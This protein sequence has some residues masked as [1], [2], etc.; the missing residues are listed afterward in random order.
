MTKKLRYQI[1]AIT[2]GI[3]GL[4]LLLNFLSLAVFLA[5]S[6]LLVARLAWVDFRVEEAPLGEQRSRLATQKV[7]HALSLTV[8][9]V[10]AAFTLYNYWAA[11]PRIF[12]NADH[13]VV[14][15]LG[16]DFGRAL[17]LVSEREPQRALWDRKLGELNVTTNPTENSFTLRGERFFE[18][19]Y[20]KKDDRY[21]LANDAG[22]NRFDSTLSAEFGG[23]RRLTLWVQ[24]RDREN[25]SYRYQYADADSSYAPLDLPFDRVIRTGISLR[26]LLSRN[27]VAAPD[28]G[29]VLALLGDTYLVR[30]EYLLQKN[31]SQNTSPLRLFPS[32]VWADSVVALSVDGTAVALARRPAFDLPLAAGQSFYVGLRTKRTTTYFLRREGERAALYLGFPERHYLR[33]S[34]ADEET[35]F[36]TSS[37]HHIT[38]TTLLAGL[39]FDGPTRDDNRNHLTA[40]LSYATGPTTQKMRFRVVNEVQ[41]NDLDPGL[42][43]QTAQAGDTL[44]MATTGL[45]TDPRHDVRW[46]LAVEDLKATN[47]LP[48]GA[49]LSYILGFTVLALLSVQLTPLDRIR[50]SFKVE[51]GVYLALLAFMT[52]RTVILWRAVTFVP[53]D[54][55]TA[56]DYETLRGLRTYFWYQIY[57][58][59]AFFGVI[60]GYKLWVFRWHRPLPASPR[61]RW[62]QTAWMP[63]LL[64]GLYG[65]VGLKNVGSLERLMSVLVPVATYFLIDFVFQRRAVARHEYAVQSPEYRFVRKLNW[66]AALGAFTLGDAGFAIIFLVFSLLYW[67]LRKEAFP[68]H[69]L[70]SQR[71]THKILRQL[72]NYRLILIP[73]LLL[74]FIGFSPLILSFLFRNVLISVELLLGVAVLLAWRET[75]LSRRVRLL[76]AGILLGAMG[77]AFAL[78]P[79]LEALAQ[80]KN[81][82][83]YRAEVRFRTA[84]DIIAAEQFNLGN[85]RRLLNAAQNQWFINYFYEK[86]EFNLYNYFRRV[87]H[88]QQGSSYLTQISDL[89]SVRYVIAEHSEWVL[90]GLILLLGLLTFLSVRNRMPFHAFTR[91]RAQLLCFLFA[92]SFTIWLAASDRMVF[93]GQDFPLLSLNSLLTLLVGFGL[94]LLVVLAGYGE[95]SVTETEVT[96]RTFEFKGARQFGYRAVLLVLIFA[97]GSFFLTN[98]NVR[99]FDL[100]QTVSRLEKTFDGLNSVFELYQKDVR[101]ARKMTPA[102]LVRGFD[103]YL[104]KEDKNFFAD[105]PFERSA[106]DAFRD[107][108][109]QVNSPEQLV[110]LRKNEDGLY[111]FAVN[112]F[113]YNV[114]SPDVYQNSWRGHLTS[115]SVHKS[116]SIGSLTSEAR[117][118]R[119]DTGRLVTDL[120]AFLANKNLLDKNE[121]LNLRLSLVPAGWTRD[122]LP[123]LLLGRTQGEERKTRSGFLIKNGTEVI[124]ADQTR[125][126][127]SLRANDVLHLQPMAPAGKPSRLVSLK[128]AQKTG[129]YLAKNS[130]IN[131]RPQ[132]YYPLRERSLWTYYFT[133]LVKSSY[134]LRPELWNANVQTT[135]DPILSRQIYDRMERYFQPS[136]ANEKRGFSLVVLD[137][138]G[139]IRALSDYKTD[140]KAR[141]DP[142]RMNE[143]ADLFEQLYLD[144][145]SYNDRNLFGNRCLVRMP[146]GPAS[147]FK[148]ILYGAVTSQ[149]DLGWPKLLFGGIGNYPRQSAGGTDKL[150]RHFGGRKMRLTVGSDNLG[151]HDNLFYISHSTNTY[152]SMMVFLGSLTP[153]QM[154]QVARG[155]RDRSPSAYLRPGAHPTQSELNFPL[156]KYDQHTYRL[157]QMP[158][159]DQKASLLATG[160]SQNFRLPLSQEAERDPEAAKDRNLAPGLDD[161]KFNASGSSYKL[162]S[163]PEPSH[164]YLVDRKENTQNAI[165]QIAMGAYPITVTPLKM[166]EMAASLFSFNARYHASILADTPRPAGYFSVGKTW[167]QEARLLSFYSQNLFKAMNLAVESGTARFLQGIAAPGYHLYAKTGTISGDRSGGAFRDKNLL[168]VISQKPLHDQPLNTKTMR[169]NKFYVLYFSFYS[170]ASSSGAWSDDAKRTARDLVNYI[171]E[172]DDFKYLMEEKKKIL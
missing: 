94:L 109:V 51:V 14:G 83:L 164:L 151:E 123:V 157:D 84:D 70:S 27:P 67:Y 46:I 42:A 65:L 112:G 130:W 170:D 75:Y 128:V 129:E 148:P 152:N 100:N 53:L 4:I 136:A 58:T 74:A 25:V 155:L 30:E 91:L 43:L 66:L 86:G 17:R 49:L 61:W 97:V 62:F 55:A 44:R 134:D 88:F 145:S 37:G 102:E 167:G 50:N 139:R 104:Q 23:G 135:L 120:S 140:P 160:L 11:P 31:G 1:A 68:D 159:W 45:A 41:Q 103:V 77:L 71:F 99:R 127:L 110:H 72:S 132:H 80:S 107:R 154:G 3:L 20:F 79:R 144:P 118:V 96:H 166:A 156:I 95:A 10:A 119:L 32:R 125:H 117:S 6:V 87:P 38:N 28:F 111:E 147:T 59:L 121:N 35:L 146:N 131:G 161:E 168:L 48:W 106:Y 26:D 93:V 122:S 150:I 108:Y 22:A 133:N 12:K 141:L 63:Y 7:L 13:H 18:P 76:A 36:L 15:H 19:I 153:T 57:F 33:S 172:S 92:L 24:N 29:A 69:R 158:D 64:F 85:D 52:V 171:Q 98:K 116:L 81:R 162:W 78:Q 165:P 34:E 113:F 9:G 2:L 82:M 89:V 138:E 21:V 16:Y 115:A 142:N 5:I 126:A 114:N 8:A 143:Y 39:L 169:D 105:K 163:F 60:L 56:T 124:S 54:D 73:L 47:G 137:S 101:S 40:N 90:V 149:Y